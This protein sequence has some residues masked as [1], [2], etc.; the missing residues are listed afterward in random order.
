MGAE[1]GRKENLT[2]RDLDLLRDLYK[3]RYLSVTQIQRLHFPSLQTAYR[4]IRALLSFNCIDGF[5]AP[6]IPEHIYYLEKA[7][8]ELVARSLGVSLPELKWRKL[9]REPK[10]YY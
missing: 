5:T 4:R 10:D 2:A 1:K 3:Y 8:A 7:G 9:D 6:H